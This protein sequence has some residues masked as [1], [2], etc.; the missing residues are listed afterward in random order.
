MTREAE[1]FPF[2]PPLTI[3]DLP[4]RLSHSRTK[5]ALRFTD[6]ERLAADEVA[7]R[8]AYNDRIAY[9]IEFS[10]TLSGATIV[11]AGGKGNYPLTNSFAD[12]MRRPAATIAVGDSAHPLPTVRRQQ[13][14]D[15]SHR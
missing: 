7:E 13:P 11:R 1:I 6:A 8:L 10:A 4:N 2:D 3:E 5:M 15:L 12:R 9:A 14:T